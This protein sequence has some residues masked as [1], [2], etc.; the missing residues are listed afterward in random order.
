MGMA[1]S[2]LGQPINL[3]PGIV[4]SALRLSALRETSLARIGL[5]FG[6]VVAKL[7]AKSVAKSGVA[8]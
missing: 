2:V 3:K 5:I 8:H 6:Q 7:V 1:Q 4:V